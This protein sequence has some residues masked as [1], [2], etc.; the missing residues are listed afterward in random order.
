M[1][2]FASTMFS[3]WRMPKKA[4]SVALF[5]CY[6]QSA[7]RTTRDLGLLQAGAQALE[8]KALD[9]HNRFQQSSGQN[10]L[11][12]R[13]SGKPG[14]TAGASEETGGMCSARRVA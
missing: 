9:Q 5:R 3:T 2:P 4:L 10:I 14:R 8:T 12:A 6:L 1:R 11:R 7:L 13:A